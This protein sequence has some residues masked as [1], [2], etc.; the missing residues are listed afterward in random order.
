MA[1][2]N[3]VLLAIAVACALAVITTQHRARKLFSEMESAQAVF[4]AALVVGPVISM[5]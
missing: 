2:V 3:I 1:R 4:R 5:I